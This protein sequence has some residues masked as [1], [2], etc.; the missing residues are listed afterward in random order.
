MFILSVSLPCHPFPEAAELVSIHLSS[1]P[2]HLC[3]M[4]FLK[5]VRWFIQGSVFSPYL[6]MV[7]S[8]HIPINGSA[9]KGKTPQSQSH[10]PRCFFLE[11]LYNSHQLPLYAHFVCP[12]GV[13]ILDIFFSGI[14]VQLLPTSTL[15]SFC[16]RKSTPLGSPLVNWLQGLFCF[17]IFCERGLQV[18][19]FVGYS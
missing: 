14:S 1:V 6:S 7:E 4:V 3:F 19:W 13:I 16:L 12:R 11:L 17:L 15:C 10:H 2:S 8:L 9:N 18:G 5:L